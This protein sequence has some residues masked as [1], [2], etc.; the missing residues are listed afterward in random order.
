[1]AGI[2]IELTV[3]D[4]GSAR[5]GAAVN[6]MTGYM[7][8]AKVAAVG[9]GVGIAAASLSAVGRVTRL[10][11]SLFSL[12]SILLL[13]SGAGLIALTSRALDFL[14]SRSEILAEKF[15]NIKNALNG[16]IA[17][18]V[19]YIARNPELMRMFDNLTYKITTWT[20]D[21]PNYYSMIDR[22][23][24]W[25]VDFIQITLP[26]LW[27]QL[28]GVWEGVKNFFRDT[29]EEVKK[30]TE[31]IKQAWKEAQ[32][33]WEQIKMWMASKN[34]TSGEET[35]TTM[36]GG[37]EEPVNANA[38]NW[39][40]TGAGGNVFNFNQNWSRSDAVNIVSEIEREEFRD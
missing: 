33:A 28:K 37:A 25:T 27:G 31:W 6:K 38:G 7:N 8:Y 13:L 36:H 15:G 39:S 23:V 4:K 10:V 34:I 29:W 9:M 1:M 22:I 17:K 16:F 26:S 21:L 11:T 40:V 19:D 20:Q 14:S 32:V 24:F 30:F 12:R 5:V 35:I 2:D 3:T 18:I